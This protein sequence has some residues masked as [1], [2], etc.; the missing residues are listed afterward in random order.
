MFI[1]FLFVVNNVSASNVVFNQ[2]FTANEIKVVSNGVVNIVTTFGGKTETAN[3]N[4]YIDGIDFAGSAYNECNNDSPTVPCELLLNFFEGKEV[5]FVLSKY[6]GS[7][8]LF[9]G[10]LYVDGKSIKDV[11][12]RNGWYRFDYKQ[13]R[14]RYLAIL[15]KEAKCSARGIWKSRYSPL[16]EM[17]CN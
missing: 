9:S 7:K 11:M 16:T 13:S 8:N 10:Q 17:E 6:D 5:K 4:Y 2:T 14:N 1:V 15:Q 3:F 12:I